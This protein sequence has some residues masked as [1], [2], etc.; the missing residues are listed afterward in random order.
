M[1]QDCQRIGALHPIP[2]THT[3]RRQFCGGHAEEE[4]TEEKKGSIDEI[5]S[6]LGLR[7]L[8][9]SVNHHYSKPTNSKSRGRMVTRGPS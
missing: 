2:K 1:G 8:Q 3:H 5:A 7:Q 4:S 6:L 9:I